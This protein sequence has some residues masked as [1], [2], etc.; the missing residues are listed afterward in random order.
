[1][2]GKCQQLPIAKNRRALKGAGR[3]KDARGDFGSARRFLN[4]KKKATGDA[5][6]NEEKPM[7]SHVDGRDTHTR[8]NYKTR[9][10]TV[11][12]SPRRAW[13]T[14]TQIWPGRK[15]IFFGAPQ[16][17]VS[18]S[19]NFVRDQVRSFSKHKERHLLSKRINIKNCF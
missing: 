6:C 19:K 15:A 8:A 1:M 9:L 14:R 17:H 10:K 18:A 12:A 7:P 4:E 13:G 16:S 3:I 5:F 11:R 2:Q